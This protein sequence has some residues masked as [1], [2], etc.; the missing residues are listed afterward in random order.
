MLRIGIAWTDTRPP[1]HFM[2]PII[3][4]TGNTVLISRVCALINIQISLFPP[5][6][7]HIHLPDCMPHMEQ[8]CR[9]K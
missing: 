1:G 2:R 9:P 6:I 3:F 7:V 4:E 5:I 8:R